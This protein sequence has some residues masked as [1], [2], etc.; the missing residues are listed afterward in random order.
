MEPSVLRPLVPEALTLELYDG[1]GVAHHCRPSV[2]ATCV[3]VEFRLC[4]SCLIFPQVNVR[5]CV[6]RDGKPG[7]FNFSADAASLSA[8]WFARVFFRIPYWHAA[9]QVSGA[10]VQARRATQERRGSIRFRSRRL[11][12]PAALSGPATF[13]VAYAPAGAAERARPGSLDEFLIERYCVYSCHRGKLY[14]T[15]LH[16]QP[17]PLQ[18]ASVELQSNSLAEPLGL[19][20]PLQPDLCHFSR[21]NKLLTW[22]PERV[23]LTR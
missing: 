7:I 16:H 4:P 19:S 8:V 20:L 6:S 18:Q 14:R 3:P 17:W 15:E 10:T 12:G 1:V 23:Q 9:I 22:A 21:C 2:P 13:D 11:H 5:T